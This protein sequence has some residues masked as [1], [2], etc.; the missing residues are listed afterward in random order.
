MFH[1]TSPGTKTKGMTDVE[2]LDTEAVALTRLVWTYRSRSNY[3]MRS[4]CPFDTLQLQC[5][6]WSG[7]PQRTL[8]IVF[9]CLVSDTNWWLVILSSL[10][11]WTATQPWIGWTVQLSFV[12]YLS[13]CA[14]P[15]SFHLRDGCSI[16]HW[17]H[18]AVVHP[19]AGAQPPTTP[20]SIIASK[21]Y[22]FNQAGN[23]PP[24]RYVPE[25]SVTSPLAKN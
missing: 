19:R 20:R 14:K 15:T 23:P 12:Q 1:T 6:V 11:A 10:F 8:A 21:M 17:T 13:I 5:T 4:R 25:A 16:T 22:R 18:T 7:E 9:N 24:N 3:L 2:T